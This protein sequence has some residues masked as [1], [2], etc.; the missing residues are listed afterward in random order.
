[1]VLPLRRRN[2]HFFEIESISYA[3]ARGESKVENPNAAPIGELLEAMALDSLDFP[4]SISKHKLTDARLEY[5]VRDD[6]DGWYEVL[7]GRANADTS[8]VAFR[9]LKTAKSRKAGK[10]PD[11]ALDLS[12]HAI[13]RP[14]RD[15]RSLTVA[16]TMGAG[17]HIGHVVMLLTA[18]CKLASN[19]EKNAPLFQ[20][21]RPDGAKDDD[22]NARKYSVRYRFE[23]SS[24]KSRTLDEALRTGEFK[25]LELIAPEQDQFDGG[26]NLKTQKSS[27]MVFADKPEQVTAASLKN[28]LRSF[29]DLPGN[30]KYAQAKIRY[31]SH[32]GNDA[33]ASLDANALNDAFTLKEVIEFKSDVE[34]QQSVP[35][36]VIMEELRRVMRG[37]P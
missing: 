25:S 22:G 33:T 31:K 37:V 2:V 27:L 26:G 1:M 13:M 12:A 16:L 34:S 7:I 3:T 35:S 14:N 21:D 28:A 23:S 32:A 8:D 19:E 11:E 30:A 15:G 17:V 6:N 36:E 20:F 29:R 24:L 5:A 18:A 4:F 10:T 9:D